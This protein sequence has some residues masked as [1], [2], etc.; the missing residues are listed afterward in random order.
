MTTLAETIAQSRRGEILRLILEDGQFGLN[1]RV[2]QDCLVHV[3]H[4]VAIDLVKDDLHWLARHGLLNLA[5]LKGAGL[6]LANITRRGEDVALGR[7][8][9]PGVKRPPPKE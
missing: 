4:N 6:T 8:V 5:E 3:G 9:I 7:E 1:E 2:I